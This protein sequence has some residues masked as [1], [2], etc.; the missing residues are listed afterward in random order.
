[1]SGA[2]SISEILN[3]AKD[4]ERL[5]EW[6]K[7]SDIYRKALTVVS[8]EDSLKKGEISERLAYAVFKSA[9][10]V[11]NSKDFVDRVGQAIAY[12]R[13][14]ITIYAE[15]NEA[16]RGPRVYRC[17]AMTAFAQY[18]KMAEPSEKKERLEESWNLTM[19]ALAGFDHLAEHDEY[20]KTYN[21]LSRSIEI[22]LKFERDP[23]VKDRTCK[24]AVEYGEKTIESLLSSGDIG[25]LARAY[26]K[27]AIL[28]DDIGDPSE[29]EKYG[30]SKKVDEYRRKAHQL[31]EADA[32]LEF[33]TA[34]G[35]SF[36]SELGEDSTLKYLMATLELAKKTKDKFL[37]GGT[38]DMLAFHAHQYSFTK[39]NSE[40]IIELY[41]RAFQHAKDA[42]KNFSSIAYVSCGNGLYWAD[43]P[44]ADYYWN[45]SEY[46]I[47]LSKRHLLL[48]KALD[49]ARD[50]LKK[51]EISGYPKMLLLSHILLGNILREFAKAETDRDSKNKILEEAYSHVAEGV[52][53]T[54]EIWPF[55]FMIRGINLAFL[56][57]IKS[58]LADFSADP[59][60]RKSIL[61][62]AIIDKEKSLGL[63]LKDMQ[64]FGSS[65]SI[66]AALGRYYFEHGELLG[67]LSACTG[68]RHLLQKAIE[69]FEKATES[70][71]K[72]E[73][74]S[75]VAEC[76]WK[77]A[78]AYDAL[79]EN[80][81]A[82]GRFELASEDY[83]KG[84][85][86]IPQ[87]GSF[88]S[89][90]ASYMLAWSEIEKARHH[91]ARQEYG[92]AMEHFEKAAHIHESLT[93]WNYLA[94]NYSAWVRLD[95]AEGLSRKEESEEA[96]KAFGEAAKLFGQSE[97]SI[98]TK[99]D[100]IEDT[101][102]KTMAAGLAKASELRRE[103][104]IG[105]IVLE[106]ARILD[107]K[108]D[109][110][111]SSEK[112]GRAASMFDQI[113]RALETDQEKKELELITTLSLA[114]QKMTRAET[115]GS[116]ALYSEA[117][118]LFEKAKKLSSNEKAKMLALG[119]SRFCKAL[120]L[121][122][123]FADTRDAT[124][125][126]IAE[127]HLESASNYYMKAGIQNASEYSKATEHLFDAYLSIDE[128]KRERD[129]EKKAR[130]YAVA[131]RVLQSAAGSFTKA[132]HP[133]KTEQVQRLIEKV[134]EERELALSLN[135]LLHAPSMVSTT[136]AFAAP[137][138]T[139][140][141]AVGLERFQQAEVNANVI[142]N[143]R[144][145]RVGDSLDLEIELANAG[146]G[147]ALL[148][149]IEKVVP[150]GFD[151][152]AKPESYRVEGSNINMK[153]KRLGPLKVE[154]VKF[155]LKPKQKGS[156]TIGPTIRY[157]DE[158]GNAK[159]H[160]PAPITITVR[161][162]G[163]IGWIKGGE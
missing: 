9:F 2:S 43:A 90:L 111:S 49:A 65:A 157:L 28:L 94:P 102:E 13:E 140:E 131:E 44:E 115:E 88:Y 14:A 30:C 37:I 87:L 63:F 62:D 64:L 38:H 19:K 134:K 141:N 106:E 8:D 27:T 138:P 59:E 130:L 81:K 22:W 83:A 33:I 3:E 150:E 147:Q 98:R 74:V 120:E 46:E 20:G 55:N 92:L 112:Y 108:G 42:S 11:D 73:V 31:S 36:Q 93:R 4:E 39:N 40:D 121:G 142:P 23:L 26:I 143:R 15:S 139:Y 1:M 66:Y 50:R 149:E 136:V 122:T 145:L 48:N 158:N 41:R 107:K 151:L 99:L 79:G 58:F 159:S 32:S 97:E 124:L 61:R 6:L 129:P 161:E 29:R 82:A 152:A 7:A 105:R 109:H 96:C 72:P 133:E 78:A 76:H 91:H 47:D 56:V 123:I 100:K 144:E 10:Q 113:T 126:T 75:R 146:K 53:I 24:K 18:W 84:V 68:D 163:I 116:P 70:Y 148:T 128:A 35:I 127:Q 137:A 162:I 85:E 153:G 155:S 104:C 77:V 160:Q 45:L 16:K 119:H 86:K 110:Y 101:P 71:Q 5:H 103:Y 25:E 156:F 132:E 34:P 12:Y 125:H 89:E 118:Q 114:W 21:E 57:T 135:D 17:E 52:R 69:A 154:E 51:A 80:E 95:D 67:R 117:A 60:K 54:D